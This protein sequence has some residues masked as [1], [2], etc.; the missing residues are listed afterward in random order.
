MANGAAKQM[1]KAGAKTRLRPATFDDYAQIAALQARFGL[2][3]G[4]FDQW[5]NLWHRMSR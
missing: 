2:D 4:N 5:T 1:K 3:A